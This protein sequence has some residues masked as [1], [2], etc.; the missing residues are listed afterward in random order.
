MK[1][2]NQVLF[3]K[4]V[5]IQPWYI[6]FRTIC[7]NV[8][9]S[10]I[11]EEFIKASAVKK[12]VRC[13]DAVSSIVKRYITSSVKLPNYHHDPERDAQES[14]WEVLNSADLIKNTSELIELES[15]NKIDLRKTR[16]EAM[17]KWNHL[18]WISNISG[19]TL[20]NQRVITFIIK[21]LPVYNQLDSLKRLIKAPRTRNGTVQQTINAIFDNL[22]T[23]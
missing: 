23:H 19:Y 18:K 1:R 12:K 9:L 7:R 6:E 8:G 15:K 10:Q 13:L 2:A 22:D 20:Y 16:H 4:K 14:L 3:N 11:L 21:N 5:E 17:A